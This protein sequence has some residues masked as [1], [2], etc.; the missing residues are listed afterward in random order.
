[1]LE[2]MDCMKHFFDILYESYLY[3]VLAAN[4]NRVLDFHEAGFVLNN[5]SNA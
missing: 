5:L 2:Q 1:M 3:P 4:L